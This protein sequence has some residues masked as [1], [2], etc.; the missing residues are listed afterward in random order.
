MY[1]I[2][3]FV[4][5]STS[6]AEDELRIRRTNIC[7]LSDIFSTTTSLSYPNSRKVLKGKEDGS[8]VLAVSKYP[9]PLHQ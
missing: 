5:T 1:T 6:S 9:H 2:T 3:T 8:E 4:H 7:V